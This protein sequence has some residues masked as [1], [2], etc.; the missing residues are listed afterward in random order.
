MPRVLTGEVHLGWREWGEG[1]TIVVFIHGNLASKDWIELAA[2][3]FPSGIRAVGIDWRGCGESDRR[4]PTKDYA[5]YSTS[6]VHG[7]APVR[8]ALHDPPAETACL[9]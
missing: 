9:G 8:L 5:N 1:D 6:D 7:S 3:L 2:P 4:P